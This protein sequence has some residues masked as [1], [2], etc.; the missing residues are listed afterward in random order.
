MIMPRAHKI[1]DEVRDEHGRLASFTVVFY[2]D[3]NREREIS[4]VTYKATNDKRP[5]F[6][7]QR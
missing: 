2:A 4:R 6:V 5:T 7:K 1:I 3:E